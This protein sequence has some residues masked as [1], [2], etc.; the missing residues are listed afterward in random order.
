MGYNGRL[1]TDDDDFEQ[2]KD[3]AVPVQ[4]YLQ[5]QHD[6]IGFVKEVYAHYI[7]V[8]DTFY[9][10]RVFTFVSRPGY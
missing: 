2:H 1:I 10:R 6:D 8:N 4:I 5:K 9:N 3:E 7:K